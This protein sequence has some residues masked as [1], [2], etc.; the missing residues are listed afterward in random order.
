MS[1]EKFISILTTLL[2]VV[3]G[4]VVANLFITQREV[5]SAGRIV[6]GGKSY[7]AK[8]GFKKR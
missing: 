3:V 2:V 8:L 5:D 4:V 6:E 1:K 7:K